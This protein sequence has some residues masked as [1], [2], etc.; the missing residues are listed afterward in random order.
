[1]NTTK[2]TKKDALKIRVLYSKKTDRPTQRALAKQFRTTPETIARIASGIHPLVAGPVVEPIENS[3]GKGMCKFT[4]AQ[5]AKIRAQA[6][7]GAPQSKLADTY[8]VSEMTI[9]R[10]IKGETY[11]STPVSK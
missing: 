4:E 7:K 1:M 2:L 11:A 10:I 8:N 6:A 3:R 9:Y 5:V